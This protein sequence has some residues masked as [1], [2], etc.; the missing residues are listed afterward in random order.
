[1]QKSSFFASG[2]T[3][4]EVS[5]IQAST[6]MPRGSLPML[7]LGVLL[8]T[9]KLN[10]ENCE[11]L[12][13]QIKQRLSSWS[14][15]ALSFAG[16]LLLIKTVISGVSTFWCSSFILPKSCIN[17]INSLCGQ[18]LW[19]GNIEGHHTA[20]VSWETVTLTKDQDGFG[21]KDLHKW[22]LACILKLVWMIFFRPLLVSHARSLPYKRSTQ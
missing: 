2:L 9:K 22:N 6:G 3:E 8:C 15:K 20:R 4:E 18:F 7:Y 5:T 10:L 19:N 11:L 12:L 16:R 21:I 17:K 1:M 13:Q 14:A